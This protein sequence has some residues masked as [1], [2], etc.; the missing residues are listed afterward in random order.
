MIRVFTYEAYHWFEGK[1]SDGTVLSIGFTDV[2]WNIGC[3]LGE[4]KVDE[5]SGKW[6]FYLLAVLPNTGL[7]TSNLRAITDKLDSLNAEALPTKKS[8]RRQHEKAQALRKKAF[9]SQSRP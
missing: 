8:T 7:T 4:L 9:G 6:C 2:V 1:P 5:K 3:T